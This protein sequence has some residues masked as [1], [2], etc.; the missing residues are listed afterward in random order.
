M[1]IKVNLFKASPH[2]NPF[3]LLRLNIIR[4]YH[5]VVFNLAKV[6]EVIPSFFLG[7][8]TYKI[9]RYSSIKRCKNDNLINQAG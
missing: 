8:Y 5:Y 9:W 7:V 3:S 4:I 1:E 6:N 2:L